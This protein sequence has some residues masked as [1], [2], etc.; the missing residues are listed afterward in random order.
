MYRPTGRYPD[1]G[2]AIESLLKPRAKSFSP[3]VR[4]KREEH[5]G[6]DYFL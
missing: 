2:L 1:R 4:S 6:S 5:D 3:L